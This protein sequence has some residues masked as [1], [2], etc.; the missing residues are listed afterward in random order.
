[1]RFSVNVTFTN[2]EGKTESEKSHYTTL[3]DAMEFAQEECKWSMTQSCEVFAGR[4]L[5]ELLGGDFKK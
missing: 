1:M 4:E 3:N 5:V 2:A